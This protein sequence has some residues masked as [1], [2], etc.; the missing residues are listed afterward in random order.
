MAIEKA[1]STDGNAIR[2]ALESLG[3]Y[4]GLIK[5]YKQPFTADN[6]D[7]L[8]SDD[9]VMVRYVGNDIHPVN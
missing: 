8:G 1:G 7:A 6:H 5:T 3:T 4:E 2:Q 9:Y